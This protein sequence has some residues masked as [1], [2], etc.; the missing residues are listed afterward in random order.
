MLL[1][2]LDKRTGCSFGARDVF[3]NIAG[4][5]E[6]SEPAADLAVV[7]LLFRG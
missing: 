5:L 3:I 7:L 2:V 4:G 6:I 1:A